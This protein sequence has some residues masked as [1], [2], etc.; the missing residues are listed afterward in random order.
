MLLDFN[1][2]GGV[3]CGLNELFNWT[4]GCLIVRGDSGAKFKSSDTSCETTYITRSLSFPAGS[5]ALGFSCFQWNYHC[6]V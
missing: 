6:C 4:T 1:T 5:I 2:V 3:Q